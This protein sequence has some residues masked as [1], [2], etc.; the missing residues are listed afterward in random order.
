MKFTN[1][2]YPTKSSLKFDIEDDNSNNIGGV[3]AAGNDD[4]EFGCI[5][6]IDQNHHG[7]KIGFQAFSHAFSLIDK[8]FPVKFINA[9]WDNS[10]LFQQFSNSQSSNLTI[11]RNNL[12]HMDSIE[13][14]KQ[15][16]TGKWCKQLGFTKCS[17]MKDSIS[18]VEVCF[19]K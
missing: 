10:T 2:Q 5:I 6:I 4:G 15:T 8:I 7:K 11:Y 9:S 14:A 19:F 12:N 18:K 1:L 13:S 3:E 17:I 16:P